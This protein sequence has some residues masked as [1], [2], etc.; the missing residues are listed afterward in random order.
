MR[1]VEAP[2]AAR[3]VAGEASQHH[4]GAG[5]G[6]VEI[7]MRALYESGEL[8]R[9]GGGPVV[10]EKVASVH[11]GEKQAAG[12]QHVRYTRETA[13]QLLLRQEIVQTIVGT[14]HQIE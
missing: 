12:P 11:I 5:V 8:K 1:L 7:A 14:G 6:R 4:R 9:L 2:V 10:F 13:R 3:V